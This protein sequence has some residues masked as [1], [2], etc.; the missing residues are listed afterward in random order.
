MA[1]SMRGA[2]LGVFLMGCRAG[3]VP[4]GT[5]TQ[6]GEAES[7]LAR[8]AAAVDSGDFE[9]AYDLLAAPL[10][11][12]YTPGTL[13]RDYALEPLAHERLERARRALRQ[14]PRT[15]PD[16]VEFPLGD[17]GAVRLV[18]EGAALRIA[19]LE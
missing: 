10:R 11:A 17:G 16:A 1:A 8:F 12:R 19:A 2:L 18:R 13:A 9:G 5:R 4:V 3:P 15:S 6:A 14:T 7:T